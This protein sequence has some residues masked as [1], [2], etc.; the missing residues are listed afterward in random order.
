[1]NGKRGAG[2]LVRWPA[3]RFAS[4][5][6]KLFFQIDPRGSTAA[7]APSSREAHVGAK[8]RTPPALHSQQSGLARSGHPS[9]LQA[10]APTCGVTVPI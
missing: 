4:L 8:I 6:G 2:W 1:M 7:L 5:R 3:P 9:L 10:A